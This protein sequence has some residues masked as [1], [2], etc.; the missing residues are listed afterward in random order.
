MRRERGTGSWDTITKNGVKYYRFRKKYD[1]MENPKSF[2]G[3]TKASVKTKIQAYEEKAVR[4][5]Q[6]AYNRM[7]LEECT[8]NVLET[9]KP[10]FKTNN[11]ATLQS[12][13]RCYIQT[14]KIKD[15]QMGSI[16]KRTIQ[17][18]YNE[19]AEKYSES[20]VKKTRTLF[21]TVFNYLVDNNILTANPAANIKMPHK[22]QY[23][24]QKKKHSFL[25][26]EEAESFYQTSLMKA[27]EATPG[28]RTG[29]YIYGR[30]ARFC[31]IILYTGMRIGEAY[32]L[33][34]GDVDFDKGLIYINKSMERIKINE[35]YQ[36]VVDTV[37]RPKSNR[38]IPL[39]ERARESFM[40]L[41]TIAPGNISKEG[42]YIFVTANNIPPSQSTVT[43]TLHAILDR[44]GI[45]S[46]GF[47]LHDLRHSFGSML[48]QKG[49]KENKP[50]DIKVIS[51]ILGHEDIST[52]YNIY[53]HILDE[54]KTEAVKLLDM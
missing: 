28:V 44:C 16:E 30:N 40:Y 50:V 52:T 33:T 11:Y 5:T 3:K 1:G 49:W 35:K 41:K 51:D 38:S 32:A 46:Y 9:L 18:F 2:I 19:L 17:S 37:K 23:A 14:N 34:W 26:L 8:E 24:V 12:T 54:H 21:N 27:T 20:T 42:D 53:M 43:R 39:S 13:F 15:L 45:E 25:S 47:G 4:V 31:I 36:W 29:D 6:T 7:T 22:T 48:L 10:T